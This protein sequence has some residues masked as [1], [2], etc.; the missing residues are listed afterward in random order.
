M[1]DAHKLLLMPNE[2]PN[3]NI[4]KSQVSRYSKAIPHTLSHSKE[5][6]HLNK[7]EWEIEW[8]SWGCIITMLEFTASNHSMT[9]HGTIGLGP[10]THNGHSDLTMSDIVVSVLYERMVKWLLVEL[11]QRSRNLSSHLLE[12]VGPRPNG[13]IVT[14]FIASNTSIGR[15]PTTIVAPFGPATFVTP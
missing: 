6:L 1:V 9:E 10:M 5:F 7:W 8:T 11:V 13:P 15:T 12:G 4:I 3:H 2:A 14:L